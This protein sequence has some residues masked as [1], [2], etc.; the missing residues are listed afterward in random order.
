M[1]SSFHPQG[2]GA[3]ERAHRTLAENLTQYVNDCHNDWDDYIGAVCYAYNTAVNL[4]STGCSPF[5]LMF[6]R[7]PLSPLDTVLPA[8]TDLTD[9]QM[10]SE[11]ILKLHKAR[12]VAS[13]NM[14]LAQDKMKKQY[15]K[16]AS[17]LKYSIGDYVYCYFPDIL[18]GGSRKFCKTF[19]GPYILIEK[20]SDVN[21]KIAQ[22]YNNKVLKNTVHVNRFKPFISR[23]IKPPAPDKL[24]ELLQNVDDVH[25]VEDLIPEDIPANIAAEPI[26]DPAL[27]EQQPTTAHQNKTRLKQ[28]NKKT[29][30]TSDDED[31]FIVEKVLGKR[32]KAD[33][34]WEYLLKWKGFS[35]AH[36][37]YE[38]Y[39]NLNETLQKFV[40]KENIKI[41]Y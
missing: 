24:Y 37:T 22:A 26:Q 9:H 7:E 21:F 34:T 16:K 15:D 17:D 40:D 18:V 33:N 4:D 28:N 19:S 20:V 6:G 35:N 25:P 13:S 14:L 1:T 32:Q 8:V 3:L 36:N 38:P 30:T 41:L 31:A 29:L 12:E 5:F 10:L 27:D 23:A 39:E 11:Y 2:N